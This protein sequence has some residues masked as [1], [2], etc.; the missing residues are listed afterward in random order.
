MRL[1]WNYYVLWRSQ[2]LPTIRAHRFNSVLEGT[3]HIQSQFIE[4]QPDVNQPPNRRSNPE[5]HNWMRYDQCILSW[6]FALISESML[7]HVNRCHSSS[8]VWFTL[9]RLNLTQSKARSLQL[10]LLLQTTKKESQS[11]KLS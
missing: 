2:V 4:V 8:E 11:I 3:T 5:F 1:D 9:A 6:L 7:G 10:K